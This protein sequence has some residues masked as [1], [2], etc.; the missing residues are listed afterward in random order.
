MASYPWFQRYS[1]PKNLSIYFTPLPSAECGGGQEE[2][3]CGKPC[4]RSCSDLHGDTECSDPLGCS[5][6]CGCPGDM[7]L[8]DGACVSREQCHCRYHNISAA[9]Q[10]HR[11]ACLTTCVAAFVVTSVKLP[12]D[13]ISLFLT[14]GHCFLSQIPPMHHGN[15]LRT[16]TGRWQIQET[17]SRV[18]VK[19]GKMNLI[20]II[21]PFEVLAF[22]VLSSP[23]PVSVHVTLE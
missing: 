4:P 22:T 20:F 14:Q 12:R 5:Q 16:M 2:W 19:I 3:P 21:L 6:T 11:L 8:Q 7:V 1:H 10:N 17:A 9:G 13:L 18:T 15:G 23:P